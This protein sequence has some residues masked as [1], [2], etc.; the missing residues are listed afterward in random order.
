MAI[1]TQLLSPTAA[2]ETARVH[3]RN[4]KQMKSVKA[5]QLRPSVWESE[6]HAFEK[7][8]RQAAFLDS[9]LHDRIARCALGI[10]TWIRDGARDTN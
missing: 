2:A 6:N 4:A 9:H 8:S 3:K 1:L 10:S 7:K 5:N